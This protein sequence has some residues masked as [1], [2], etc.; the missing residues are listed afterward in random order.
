MNS[1][2]NFDYE[3]YHQRDEQSFG[4]F[5][6]GRKIINTE[7]VS[8]VDMGHLC[9]SFDNHK[10]IDDTNL[11]S[12]LRTCSIHKIYLTVTEPIY[13]C[14]KFTNFSKR[15]KEFYKIS[16]GNFIHFQQNFCSLEQ[17]VDEKKDWIKTGF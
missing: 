14:I 3:I 4:Y 2:T 7:I 11:N 17:F 13:I 9:Q 8:I 10:L 15:D 1:D 12:I 6:L 16:F 5:T